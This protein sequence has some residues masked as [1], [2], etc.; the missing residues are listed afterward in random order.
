M[1]GGQRLPQLA[2]RPLHLDDARLDVDLDALRDGDGF[3]SY[4]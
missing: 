1:P 3:L 4:T 2:L